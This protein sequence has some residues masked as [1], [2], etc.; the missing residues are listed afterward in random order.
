MI[1]RLLP[2]ACAA[3]IGLLLA[4]PLVAACGRPEP[5]APGDLPD[6]SF[7]TVAEWVSATTPEGHVRYD[8]RWRLEQTGG[9]PVG[10][11][12]AVRV[13]G[14][15]SLRLDL[16][17][18]F[19]ISGSAVVIGREVD[20]AEP[21]SLFK[22][23]IGV[24]PLV[25]ATVGRALLPRPG[26]S[27]AGQESSPRM[28]RYATARDTLVYVSEPGG[29]FSSEI[30]SPDGI[31]GR[32]VVEFDSTTGQIRRAVLS[33]PPLRSRLTLEVEQTVIDDPFTSDTWVRP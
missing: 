29:R 14:P 10:G 3:R 33:L 5:L 19:G 7:D 22:P 15:D 28:W 1:P 23:F 26:E 30:L 27:I 9:S 21:E 16:Q 8:V 4:L 31:L 11:R 17:G 12:G 2:R 20:W 24:V 25:W 32:T 13:A 18:P 6:V